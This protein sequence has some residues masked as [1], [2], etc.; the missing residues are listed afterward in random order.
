MKIVIQRVKQAKVKVNSEIIG[1]IQ[2]G[3]LILV[4]AENDDDSSDI[5][6]LVSKVL[7]LRIFEDE[8]SK[9]NLSVLDIKGEI[10]AV[11]QFTLLGD[12]TKGRRPSFDKAAKGQDALSLY[13]Q[14]VS[15]LKKSD[16]NIQTGK[17]GAH[18][19]VELIND[20]PVTFVLNSRKII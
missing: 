9:M 10:L 13:E 7:N 8:N 15:E 19:Q 5:Q 12:C 14:F 17:F 11:S 20:G 1:N 3:L 6:Y 18:M 4:G 16:L 2:Q